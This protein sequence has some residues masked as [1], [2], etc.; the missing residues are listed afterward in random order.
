MVTFEGVWFHETRSGLSMA[1]ILQSTPALG[2]LDIFSVT[3]FAATG[4]NWDH[5]AKKEMIIN[6]KYALTKINHLIHTICAFSK[7]QDL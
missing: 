6:P 4:E 7:V 1:R 3:F 2:H 5:M